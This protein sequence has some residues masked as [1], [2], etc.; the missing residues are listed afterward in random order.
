MTLLLL[1]QAIPYLIAEPF[2]LA[3]PIV[4]DLVLFL[5]LCIGGRWCIPD[6]G[7]P[8]D[9]IL[10]PFILL[11]LVLL[12]LPILSVSILDTRAELVL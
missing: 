8:H 6:A 3:H 5:I 2:D 11:D 10:H 4:L 9:L 1:D 12:L 7:H